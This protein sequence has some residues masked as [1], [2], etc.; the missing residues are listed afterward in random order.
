M[1]TR[2]TCSRRPIAGRLL[3]RAVQ[4]IGQ[5]FPHHIKCGSGA[6]RDARILSDVADAFPAGRPPNAGDR[7]GAHH[8]RYARNRKSPGSIRMPGCYRAENRVTRSRP[9][10]VLVQSEVPVILAKN[11]GRAIG[12]GLAHAV[13]RQITSQAFPVRVPTLTPF[14]GAILPL[15]DAGSG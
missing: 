1:G 8:A 4:N 3:L 6:E 10:T 11:E 13:V 7:A 14:L 9:N 5:E 2:G 12:D 15:T